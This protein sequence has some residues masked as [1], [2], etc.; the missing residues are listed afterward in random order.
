MNMEGQH[1]VRPQDLT[2]ISKEAVVGSIEPSARIRSVLG[3]WSI[4]RSLTC[5]GPSEMKF[6]QLGIRPLL[7]R[8][9]K[10]QWTD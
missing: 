9:R 3:C 1:P 5:F 10:V 4:G 8:Q 7:H 6:A 2:A